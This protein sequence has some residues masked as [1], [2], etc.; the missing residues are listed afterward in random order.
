MQI[1]AFLKLNFVLRCFFL[2]FPCSAQF[3]SRSSGSFGSSETSNRNNKKQER[4]NVPEQGVQRSRGSKLE[5]Q[6]M[7]QRPCL[8]LIKREVQTPNYRRH[9]TM[10][11]AK[12][13]LLILWSN[14]C[15]SRGF[16][17][18]RARKILPERLRGFSELDV[19][20]SSPFPTCCRKPWAAHLIRCANEALQTS[21][22]G[23]RSQL[24]NQ[25]S[26]VQNMSPSES[27]D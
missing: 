10:R 25:K 14:S 20:F 22:L 15:S 18:A 19:F 1:P 6:K 11:Q 26:S 2:M 4:K 8:R 24:R 7:V 21:A 9:H 13:M 12:S 17:E 5:T 3:A 27:L 23:S 16:C